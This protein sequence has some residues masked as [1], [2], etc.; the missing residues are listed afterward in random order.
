MKSSKKLCH[1]VLSIIFLSYFKYYALMPFEVGTEN[2][3]SFI[4]QKTFFKRIVRTVFFQ[5]LFLKIPISF[6]GVTPEIF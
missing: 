1:Q 6:I 5:Q 2:K 4:K 3:K